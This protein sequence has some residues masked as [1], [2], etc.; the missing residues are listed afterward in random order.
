L[1]RRG[2]VKAFNPLA[3]EDSRLFRALLEG[4]HSV[5][6]FSNLDIRLKLQDSP[7]LKGITEPRRQSAKVTRIFN[8]C[9]AH[10]LIAKIP[11]SR[12]WKLTRHGRMAMTCS[13]QLRDTQFPITHFALHQQPRPRPP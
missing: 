5:Q 10:G 3:R 12:R 6:G 1:R 4:E 13:L 2:A 9:H 11:R 8:R 7:H